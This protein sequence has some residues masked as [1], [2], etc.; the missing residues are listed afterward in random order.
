MI[1]GKASE[2]AGPA[3]KVEGS[4]A[5]AGETREAVAKGLDKA[6]PVEAAGPAKEMASPTFPDESEG[7]GL[8]RAA[9]LIGKM[10]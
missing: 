10:S 2:A 5:P 4:S 6:V 9:K 3:T 8:G 1:H 7:T